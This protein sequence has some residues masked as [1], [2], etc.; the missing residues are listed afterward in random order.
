MLDDIME[1]IIELFL[2]ISVEIKKR[3]DF[4]QKDE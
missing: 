1:F 4:T 3:F 2:D